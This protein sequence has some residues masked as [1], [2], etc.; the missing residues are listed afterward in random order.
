M[1]ND[2][3]YLDLLRP[4]LATVEMVRRSDLGDAGPVPRYLCLQHGGSVS[5]TV[6]LSKGQMIQIAMPG[7]YSGVGGGTTAPADGVAPMDAAVPGGSCALTT[8][9]RNQ[10]YAGVH[11]AS[12]LRWSDNLSQLPIYPDAKMMKPAARRG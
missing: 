12:S 4:R 8:A 11:A 10:Q 5:N 9:R 7:R 6:G 3:A 1:T 2:A